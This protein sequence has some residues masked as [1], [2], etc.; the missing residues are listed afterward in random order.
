MTRR[1]FVSMAALAAP[2]R[3]AA[4]EPLILPFHRVMDTRA[5]CTP[6][7]LQHFWWSIWPEAVRN[8]NR[9]GI[10][11]QCSDGKGEIHLSPGDRPIVSGLERG[12]INLV[13]THHIPL[14]WD[15]ARGLAGVTTVYEGYHLCMIALSRAHGHQVPFLSVN[16]CVHEMLH[17][18]LQDIFLKRPKPFQSGEREFRDDWYATRLWLFHDGAAIRKSAEVYLDRLRATVR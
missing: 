10:Q 13:L 18:L 5:K 15:N 11:F 1:L 6:E 8:F 14:A 12:A 2:V 3:A 4:Q 7:Q 16:T 9:C 17:V